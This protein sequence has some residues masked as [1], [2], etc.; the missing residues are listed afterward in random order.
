M[1]DLSLCENKE[2]ERALECFRFTA[3]ANPYRQAYMMDAKERCEEK[4]HKYWIP[5]FKGEQHI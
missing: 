5:N 1:T 2:C 3:E 4:E